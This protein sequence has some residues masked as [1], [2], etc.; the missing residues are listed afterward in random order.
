[1]LE[2]VLVR[3]SPFRVNLRVCLEVEFWMGG[4]WRDD[5]YF[6]IYLIF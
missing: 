4:L 5:L 1:M 3:P 2:T 6:E